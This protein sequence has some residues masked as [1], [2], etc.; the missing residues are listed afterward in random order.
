MLSCFPSQEMPEDLVDGSHVGSDGPGGSSVDFLFHSSRSGGGGVHQQDKKAQF[1]GKSEIAKVRILGVPAITV[2]S[3][4]QLG[5]SA[6]QSLLQLFGGL[7]IG[8]HAFR[9]YCCYHFRLNA[10]AEMREMSDQDYE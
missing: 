10:V 3:P 9:G 7:L 6:D 1:E 5:A 2:A 8:V 4:L